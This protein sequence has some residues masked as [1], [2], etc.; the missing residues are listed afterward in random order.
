MTSSITFQCHFAAQWS[1]HSHHCLDFNLSSSMEEEGEEE[2][3]L[4]NWFSDIPSLYPSQMDFM[5]QPAIERQAD[6]SDSF[7]IRRIIVGNGIAQFFRHSSPH[8]SAAR[9]IWIP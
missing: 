5:L 4:D 2:M 9:W 7:H 6:D 3:D 8:V 1:F